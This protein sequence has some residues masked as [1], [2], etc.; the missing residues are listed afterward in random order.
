MMVA[1]ALAT[2]RLIIEVLTYLLSFLPYALALLA[3]LTVVWTFVAAEQ[4]AR[5]A[6]RLRRLRWVAKRSKHA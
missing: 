6:A 4:A 1:R 3:M 5:V 2:L